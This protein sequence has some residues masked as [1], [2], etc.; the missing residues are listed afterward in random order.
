[1]RVITEERLKKRYL[2]RALDLIK[3]NRSMAAPQENLKPEEWA[4]FCQGEVQVLIE[5][6]LDLVETSIEEI[7]EDE[8]IRAAKK[9]ELKA[10][11]KMGNYKGMAVDETVVNGEYV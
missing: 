5:T 4:L 10:E 11:A 8:K 2:E 6:A 3:S 7:E 9:E 1:M